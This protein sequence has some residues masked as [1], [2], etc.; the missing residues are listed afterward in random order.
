M[1]VIEI[2]ADISC[3]TVNRGMEL[4]IVSEVQI[5][6]NPWIFCC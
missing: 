6:D 2:Q 3:T 1:T 4:F 5:R